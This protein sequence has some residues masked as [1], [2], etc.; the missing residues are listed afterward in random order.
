M[1][2]SAI[3][4]FVSA[5]AGAFLVLLQYFA[6][7][8][9][10]PAKLG[11]AN[12]IGTIGGVA[13]AIACI[14][15]GMRARRAEAAGREFGYGSAFAAGFQVTVV[16]TVLSAIFTYA[17]YAFINPAFSEVLTENALAK[18]QA[19]GMS[20]AKLDSMEGF[21]HHLFS[22]LGALIIALIFGTILGIV[23]SLL[24]AIFVR[25]KEPPRVA[26]A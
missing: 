8:H 3:Y 17:Y 6:G 10:D 21:Y 20:G 5:L 11:V 2:T 26:A 1:K 4:G 9:S 24:A 12:A 19:G 13:I 16:S 7:L 23:I 25:T 18:L 22:P 15:L 14:T